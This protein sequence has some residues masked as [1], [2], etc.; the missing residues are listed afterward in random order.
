[1]ANYIKQP[2]TKSRRI[3]TRSL[4]NLYSLFRAY[5]TKTES[6][7]NIFQVQWLNC[8]QNLTAFAPIRTAPKPLYTTYQSFYSQTGEHTPYTIKELLSSRKKRE[9]LEFVS[10]FGLSSHLFDSID[11]KKFGKPKASPFELDVLMNNKRF[12]LSSVGYGVSQS[13]PLVV[14][15]FVSP[16]ETWF[17]IQQPEIHLHPRAQSSL[18]D[19]FYRLSTDGDHQFKFII[20]T[21]SDFIVDSFRA[22]LRKLPNDNLDSQIVFFERNG[23]GNSLQTIN[24]FGDGSLPENQ[25]K[26]YRDFFIDEQLRVLGY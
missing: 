15:F 24:I 6:P 20:E 22:N 12:K 5:V 4:G 21:H 19:L 9:F 25:P 10:E 14:E 8:F 26:A 16:P 23:D 2:D 7:H 3:H 13:L 18:G 17:S 11:V 1:M